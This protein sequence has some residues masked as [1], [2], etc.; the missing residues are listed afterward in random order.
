MNFYKP[1]FLIA[2]KNKG[3]ILLYTGIVL[4]MTI[5]FS[6]VNSKEDTTAK[7]K[8]TSYTIYISDKDNSELS[9]KLYAYLGKLHKIKKS[10]INEDKIY[11]YIYYEEV[12]SYIVIPKGFEDEFKNTGNVKLKNTY[13][14][15]VPGGSFIDFQTNEYLNSVKGYMDA[16]YSLSDAAKE[17]EKLLMNKDLV[18]I[19]ATKNKGPKQPVSKLVFNFLPYGILMVLFGAILPIID[20]FNEKEKTAKIL[21]SGINNTKKTLGLVLGSITLAIIML[22]LFII[23]ATIPDAKNILFTEKWWLYIL[24]TLSYTITVVLMIS[25]ITNISG[26]SKGMT[27]MYSNVIGLSFAFMGGTFVPL[28][29]LSDNVKKFSRLIPN[30]WYST[31]V[32]KINSGGDLSNV[33]KCYIFEIS[34]GLICLF[35]GLAIARIKRETAE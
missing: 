21:A 12:V 9:K 35:A 18:T 17:T 32:E 30:Y 5:L 2:K 10:K 25:M 27:S 7:Y 4:L 34:F 1:F 20:S 13:D 33:F 23:I 26:T 22:L 28:E 6:V 15:S 3:P 11:D 8:S 29:I 19:K 31:A 14:D 24:N 16:G